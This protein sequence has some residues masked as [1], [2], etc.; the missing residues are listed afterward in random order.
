MTGQA[1]DATFPDIPLKQLRWSA[2]IR[3]VGGIGYYPTSGVPFVHVDTGP[4]RAWPRLPRSELALLFPDGKTKHQPA[5]GGSLS[6]DDVR[7]ARANTEVASQVATYFA[8]RS[9]PKSET[10]I[11]MAEAGVASWTPTLKAPPTQVER[12]APAPRVAAVETEVV[13]LEP[14]AAPLPKLVQAPRPANSAAIRNRAWPTQS[15]R[16]ASVAEPGRHSGPAPAPADG[17]C[18]PPP[19]GPVGQHRFG[20]SAGTGVA[21]ARGGDGPQEANAGCLA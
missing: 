10:E 16:D 2:A 4:V 14:A 13:E 3:E 20:C 9:H 15:A 8:L 12:P 21:L 1:I 19:V 18:R 17:R 11:A 7:K 6:R 5:D